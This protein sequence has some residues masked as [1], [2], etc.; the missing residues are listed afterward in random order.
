VIGLVVGSFLNVVIHRVPAGL[1]IVRPGS[2]CPSC[3]APIRARDNIPVLSWLVLHGRCRD[4]RTP[5]SARYPVVEGLTG[6]LFA[7]VALRHGR[8]TPDVWAIGA[9]WVLAAV[10]VA[11][12][13]IDLDVR[14]LPD[15]ITLFALVTGGAGLVGASLAGAGDGT[16]ALVRA[17]IGAVGMFVFHALA[18][19][20]Y[21][22]GIG[23]GDVKLAAVTGMFLAWA[24]WGPLAVGVAASYVI[25]LVFALVE[26]ARGRKGDSIPLGRPCSPGWVSGLSSA[27]RSGRHTCRSWGLFANECS[28]WWAGWRIDARVEVEAF[29]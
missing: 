15:P 5:I 6:L 16:D 21:P 13:A 9:F 27:N 10:A 23:L 11:H 29:R 26:M 14:R 19:L 4:C 3:R 22:R 1:S 28:C 8:D 17:S 18:W 24:G 25:G 2:A 12:S 20:V 7:V